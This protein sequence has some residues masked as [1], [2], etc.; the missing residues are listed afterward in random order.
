M[1]YP[2]GS[3]DLLRTAEIATAIISHIVASD[4][5]V[6]NHARVESHIDV[7]Y[8]TQALGLPKKLKN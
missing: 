5:E 2:N 3:G 6:I 1:R 7:R 8:A 4:G